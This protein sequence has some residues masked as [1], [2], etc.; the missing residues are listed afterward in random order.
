[1]EPH[2]TEV[3]SFIVSVPMSISIITMVEV[4]SIVMSVEI[5]EV[6]IIVVWHRVWQVVDSEWG[7]DSSEWGVKFLVKHVVIRW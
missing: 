1:M 6:M 3:W 7:I 5:V 2:L 4:S